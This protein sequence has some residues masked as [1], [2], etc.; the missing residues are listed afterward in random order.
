VQG[1]WLCLYA[2]VCQI[3]F[4]LSL[5]PGFLRLE[6][7]SVAYLGR[8]KLARLPESIGNMQQLQE[9]DVSG[10]LLCGGS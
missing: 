8:N 1:H 9:L 5:N 6:S 4:F 3:L 2:S 10:W 7:L